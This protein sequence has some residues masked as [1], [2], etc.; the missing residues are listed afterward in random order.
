MRWLGTAS[1]KVAY[2]TAATSL[3]VD[4]LPH[5]TFGVESARQLRTFPRFAAV[6]RDELARPLRL[7]AVWELHR[8]FEAAAGRAW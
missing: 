5:L 6:V 7:D 3:Q 8:Y 2:F 4:Q 1:E